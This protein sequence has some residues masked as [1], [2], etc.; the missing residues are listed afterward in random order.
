MKIGVD[1]RM[2]GAGNTRG[3]GRYIEELFRAMIVNH[4]ENEYFFITRSLDHA[5]K[6][7]ACVK[8]IVA[9]IPW[10]STKEQL[11]L[12]KVLNKLDVDV[13]H[14]PHWNVPLTYR[15]PYVVTIHDLLLRHQKDSSKTSTRSVFHRLAKRVGYRAVLRHAIIGAKAISVPT[16]FVADDVEFFYPSKKRKIIVTG[17]GVSELHNDGSRDFDFEYLLYVGSS[18]P[19]KRLD[20]L[21]EVWKELSQSYPDMHLVIAGETDVFMQ[22][23]KLMSES[24]NLMRIHFEGR[25]SDGELRSLYENATAF[26]FP[27]EFEGFGLPPL[28]ALALGTPVISSDSRPLPDVLGTGGVVYFKSGSGD[29]MIDAVKAV[30]DNSDSMRNQAKISGEVLKEKYTWR[31]ASEHTLEAYNLALKN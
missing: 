6:D 22:R 10:Y 12:P 26:V 19:H 23:I 15:K 28:E 14:F 16:Q 21:M 11:Y 25:V 29:G 9:D 2:M 4:P 27:S 1:A 24:M 31:N 5:L 18:Y 7:H 30:V 8:T 17:E 13:M 20:L 3:I